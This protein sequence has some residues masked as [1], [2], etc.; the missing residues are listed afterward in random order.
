MAKL[1]GGLPSDKA[2]LATEA[3]PITY[4][5]KS[6]PPFLIV[7]GD[8]DDLVPFAQS[9]ELAEKL[10]KSAVPNKLVTVRGAGHQ[11]GSEQEIKRMIEFF[12]QTLIEGKRQ[13][14][15]DS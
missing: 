15:V 12:K 9:E 4:V 3:S 11:L 8:I 5:S 14:Q 6:D 10:Q 1:L 2:E 13:F 7:H